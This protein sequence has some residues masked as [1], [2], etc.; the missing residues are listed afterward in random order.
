MV[1]WVVENRFSGCFWVIFRFCGSGGLVCVFLAAVVR[2]F[3][4][5]RGLLKS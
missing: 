2:D 4:V 1:V 3:V 5:F